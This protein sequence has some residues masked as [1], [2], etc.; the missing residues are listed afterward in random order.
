VAAV[1]PQGNPTETLSPARFAE[2]LEAFRALGLVT[3]AESREVLS[4]LGPDLP[5]FSAVR[6]ADSMH[7]HVKVD[8]VRARP[9]HARRLGGRPENEREGYVKLAF[10]GGINMMFSSIDVADEDALPPSRSKP[11]VDHVGVDMRRETGVVRACFTEVPHA[12]LRVGW[13]HKVQGGQGGRSSA[14]T[15]R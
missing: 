13:A 4:M 10:A 11:F 14:A 5:F 7:V 8:D 3:D 2:I 9:P 1:R 6:L 12:A 15:C